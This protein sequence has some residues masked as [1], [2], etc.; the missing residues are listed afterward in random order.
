MTIKAQDISQCWFEDSSFR[1]SK[2]RQG[3]L[4]S[5][6][7]CFGEIF[8]VQFFFFPFQVQDANAC[9]QVC[10][11]KRCELC[12]RGEVGWGQMR[13]AVRV[14]GMC[15]PSVLCRQT[16]VSL[17]ML[18]AVWNQI[19]D[20]QGTEPKPAWCAFHRGCFPCSGALLPLA[21]TFPSGSE[22]TQKWALGCQQVMDCWHSFPL[23]WETWALQTCLE[24][25]CAKVT[26]DGKPA[27]RRNISAES[28]CL[29]WAVL[30]CSLLS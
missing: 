8:F 23:S 29:C 3:N 6:T 4:S 13:S 14:W 1:G 16:L 27:W 22:H 2:S 10:S 21:F 25:N 11:W 5:Q 24:L 9:L 20:S 12:S 17:P 30:L 28:W 26:K 7:V 15:V 18:W 19:L